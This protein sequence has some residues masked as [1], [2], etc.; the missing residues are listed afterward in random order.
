M[1]G[2]LN[3]FFTGATG[4]VGGSILSRL[5][6]HKDAASFHITALVRSTDKAEKLK[7]LGVDTVIGSYTDKDSTFLT[8]AAS[9]ADV[10]FTAADSDVLPPAQAILDGLKLKYEASG[11]API[12]IHTSGTGILLNDARG[13]HD[14]H[15]HYSDL[16]TEKLNA[17]PVTVLHRNVDIP[18]M[19]AD[20]AG[21]VKAYLIAPSLVFGNPQGP[22]VDLGIQSLH[23]VMTKWLVK[24][25]IAR[26]NGGY[27]G[28]GVNKWAAID[29]EDNADLYIILF[30]AI[31]AN[32]DEVPRGYY[33]AEN[34]QFSFI[35]EAA[36]ISEALV[37]LGVGSSREP[38]VF[39]AEEGEKYFGPLFP[40]IGSNTYAKGDRGR[41][42]GWKP[43]IGQEAYLEY[44]KSQMKVYLR[45]E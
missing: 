23:S 18:I 10:V 2:K 3:I 6:Q 15:I 28:K 26:K 31:R 43:Q 35:E 22:L 38:S 25:A 41:A 13:L 5:L 24:A 21:Y 4:Y 20:K 8:E 27:F 34:F 1:T 29:V 45:E 14:E 36:A 7:T 12:L 32:A 44:V 33:F 40:F 39:T 9:K 42:L 16:E 19:E 37:E 17:L 11:T 30:D